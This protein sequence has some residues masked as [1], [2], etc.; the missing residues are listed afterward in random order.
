MYMA[1]QTELHIIGG[2]SIDRVPVEP[3]MVQMVEWT[4]MVR[5][6]W[7]PNSS[8][9]EVP[10]MADPDEEQVCPHGRIDVTEKKPSNPF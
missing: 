6:E 10:Y 8:N 2:D 1:M 4:P 7:N 3:V 9:S 5:M